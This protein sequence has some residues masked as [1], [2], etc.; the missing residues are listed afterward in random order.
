MTIFNSQKRL[1]LW[2]INCALLAALAA[3]LAPQFFPL[4]APESAW[5]S[6]A[7]AVAAT[8]AYFFLYANQNQSGD[9]DNIDSHPTEVHLP[10]IYPF[11]EVAT[12]PSVRSVSSVAHYF[13]AN[14][15]PRYAPIFASW[16]SVVIPTE[17]LQTAREMTELR[18]VL[19]G[20][21]REEIEIRFVVT[22]GYIT[23][24]IGSDDARVSVVAPNKGQ[25]TKRDFGF[26]NGLN[27]AVPLRQRGRYVFN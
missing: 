21:E 8:L 15:L 11:P 16:H 9:A 12:L 24:T 19:R 1:S 10:N 20:L 26:L 5:F 4:A 13:P 27:E 18:H 17:G 7:C 2:I 6:I 22:I 23:L 25:K 3:S 14:T